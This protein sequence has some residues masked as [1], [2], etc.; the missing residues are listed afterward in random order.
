MSYDRVGDTPPV[1]GWSSWGRTMIARRVVGISAVLVIVL[2]ACA[3]ARR[4]LTEP[5]RALLAEIPQSIRGSC[6]AEAAGG[7]ELP[8][9]D[10][11]I[12]GLY[13][14]PEGA[15]DEVI[16]KAH[17][18]QAS[19]DE[20]FAELVDNY[21]PRRADCTQLA[22]DFGYGPYTVDGD[23]V[24]RVMCAGSPTRGELWEI[25]WTDD[26]NNVSASAVS[27][28]GNKAALRDWWLTVT[29]ADR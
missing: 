27:V 15:A 11:E 2:T 21:E 10:G 12:A 22:V 5:Q 18:D 3:G 16:Y 14:Y 20:Y 19:L 9:L 25:A 28:D 17:V 8:L 6:Q 13:C 24:G 1:D 26:R 4:D 23:A 7:G 29:G